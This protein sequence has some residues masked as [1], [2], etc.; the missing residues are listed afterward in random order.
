MVLECA[1]IAGE[2]T[3]VS[4]DKDLLALGEYEGIRIL[5]RALILIFRFLITATSQTA[6]D[7]GTDPNA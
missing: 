3:I 2:Q 5:S 4:G 6:S 7:R 1:V